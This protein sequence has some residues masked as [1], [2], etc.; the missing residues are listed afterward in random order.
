LLLDY[1]LYRPIMALALD[2]SLSVCDGRKARAQ[3]GPVS[4][5]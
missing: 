5:K 3:I 1:A 4:R 2:L